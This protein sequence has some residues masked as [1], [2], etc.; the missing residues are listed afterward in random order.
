MMLRA[1][2]ATTTLAAA[3]L[4]V[5]FAHSQQATKAPVVSTAA[6]RV[7]GMRLASSHLVVF[8][9]IPFAAPPVGRLRWRAPQ[10][11]HPWPGVRVANHF[12]DSCMQQTPNEFLPWTPV[13]MT[14]R[15]VSE[16]CLYLNVWTPHAAAS[17]SLPV[18]VFIHGGAFT[19]GAGSISIYNG[20]HLAQTGMVV[21]TINYRVGVF[22][23]F[24]YPQLTA[25][26]PHHSSGNYGL[27]DQMAAL[28][29][30]RRN[31]RNFGGDPHRVTIWGQS[32]G[33]W[34]VEDLL[35]SPLPVGLFERAQA[36][37]GIG[38]ANG[39][40]SLLLRQAEA[41]GENFATRIGAHSLKDLRAIPAARL[42]ADVRPGDRFLP[43]VDGWVLP[44]PANQLTARGTGSH[45]PLITGNEANDWMLGSPRVSSVQQYQALAQRLYGSE[46]AKF[47]R[48]YPAKTG[49]QAVAMEKLSS[50]DRDRASMY[51]WARLRAQSPG[52]AQPIYTYYFDRAI[53]WPQH[54]EYGAFHSGELPYFFRNLNRMHRPWQPVDYEV[55]HTVSAYLKHFATTG[56]PNRAGLPHWPA[57]QADAAVTMQLGHKMGPMPLASPARL[58]FWKKYFASPQASHAPLF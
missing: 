4:G 2:A 45:V 38:L 51:L 47:L 30:V 35:L 7:A 25:E 15:H 48:L 29:W 41:N 33:A 32:A 19:S 40:H 55:S 50:E 28:R 21:V 43:D 58:A 9:G 56:D 24:A 49:A 52:P 10:P 23:F 22:G 57:V 11:V 31:I 12:S 6:G 37:S 54:P 44:A 16:D 36:D 42:L 27:L 3:M 18:V 1:L 17:A 8:K 53:P 20:A 5:P 26:S 13:F 14:H 34:S 46:A 39:F